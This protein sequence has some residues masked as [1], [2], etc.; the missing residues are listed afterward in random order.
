NNKCVRDKISINGDEVIEITI[1]N[2]ECIRDMTIEVKEEKLK[3]YLKVSCKNGRIYTLKDTEPAN[4]LFIETIVIDEKRSEAFTKEDVEKILSE[5]KIKYGVKWENIS[6]VLNGGTAVIA[7][8]RKVE[9]PI[10]DRIDYF[11]DNEKIKT[12]IE[13]DGKVDYLN[14]GEVSFVEAGKL[15]AIKIEGKDGISGVNVYGETVM[16]PKRKKIK[17][18]CGPG[19]ETFDD[20]NKIRATISGMPCIKGERIC[21]FPVHKIS[22]DVDIITGNIEFNGDIHILGDVKEGMEVKAGNSILIKGNVAEGKIQA[23]GD[24]IIEKNVISSEIHAGEKQITEKMLINTISSY[25]AFLESLIEAINEVL[26]NGKLSKNIGIEQI[27]KVLLESKF[28]FVKEIIEKGNNIELSKEI[29]EK[30]KEIWLRINNFQSLILQRKVNKLDEILITKNLISNFLDTYTILNTPADVSVGYCQNSK[31]FATND[32]EVKGKGCYNTN[33]IAENN[34]TI[35]GNPGVLRGGQV[36]VGGNIK[37]KEVGS[38][39]GVPTVLKT[40]KKGIIEAEIAYNN[41]ILCFDEITFKLEYPVK[42]LKAYISKGEL[43]VEKLKF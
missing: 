1:I 16:P 39:A 24:I 25:H 32:V 3:A 38:N 34:V 4:E 33:I 9:M 5:N 17:F 7:E 6:G 37:V 14:K 18:L 15:L 12:P 42:K 35:Y 30:L 41:T 43:I 20:G 28:K 29:N 11:F 40:S 19:C 21:V 2:D 8:G 23:K 36:V 27:I 13:V 22:G 26:T 10:D 31:I